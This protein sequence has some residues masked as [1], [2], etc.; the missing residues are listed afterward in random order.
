MK[1]VFVLIITISCFL[2]IS[3]ITILAQTP[4]PTYT[5]TFTP[6][7]DC[8]PIGN[9]YHNPSDTN[10]CT[11]ETQRFP[12]D[13]IDPADSVCIWIWMSDFQPAFPDFLHYRV[14]TGAWQTHD[15]QWECFDMMLSNHYWTY[16]DESVN[17]WFPGADYG[18][19]VD[20][21][22]EITGSFGCTEYAYASGFTVTE[23]EAQSDPYFFSYP[24]NPDVPASSPVSIVILLAVIMGF[25]GA[26]RLFCGIRWW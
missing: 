17:A 4:T 20:Y 26:G 24:S 3:D 15:F 10:T 6:T 2:I 1:K 25:M 5:P 9:G 22:F 16:C 14:N 21:Y 8:T 19:R 23:T 13:P 18:D 11:G 12:L 7:P